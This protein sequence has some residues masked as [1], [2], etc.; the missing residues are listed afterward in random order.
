MNFVA[1]PP[2]HHQAAA[3]PPNLLTAE[4]L[5]RSPD[6][7]RQYYDTEIIFDDIPEVEAE[8]C[9]ALLAIFRDH[10]GKERGTLFGLHLGDIIEDNCYVT[11]L[12]EEI[13]CSVQKFHR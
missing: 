6:F 12:S 10:A 8:E 4:L 7:L 9:A 13:W 1:I 3:M 2:R 11:V 5:D